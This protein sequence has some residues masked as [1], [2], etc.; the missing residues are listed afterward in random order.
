METTT[1]WTSIATIFIAASL[2]A[3]CSQPDENIADIPACP[4]A[5]MLALDDS[6]SFEVPDMGTVDMGPTGAVIHSQSPPAGTVFTG[7]REFT[8]VYTLAPPQEPSITCEVRSLLIDTSPPEIALSGAD[9]E[10]IW[11]EPFAPVIE[12]SD[13][14]DPQPEVRITVN[15]LDFEPGQLFE[16]PGLYTVL[17]NANDHRGNSSEVKRVVEIAEYPTVDALVLPAESHCVE[18]EGYIELD[19]TILVASEADL[20]DLNLDTVQLVAWD[21]DGRVLGVL[22]PTGLYDPEGRYNPETGQVFVRDGY[23]SANFTSNAIDRTLSAC[24]AVVQII[25]SGLRNGP[26]T[27]DLAGLAELTPILSPVAVIEQ[28]GMLEPLQDA[29]LAATPTA[30]CK[31]E[32][33]KNLAP[34]ETPTGGVARSKP[35][36]PSDHDAA[37]YASWLTNEAVKF[38]H[39]ATL[40]PGPFDQYAAPPWERT[41]IRSLPGEFE[42][43][44]KSKV[45]RYGLKSYKSQ[46]TVEGEERDQGLYIAQTL[47]L[48]RDAKADPGRDAAEILAQSGRLQRHGQGLGQ[49][50]YQGDLHARRHSRRQ[51]RHHGPKT[52]SKPRARG[53]EYPGPCG[54]RTR[55]ST[56]ASRTGTKSR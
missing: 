28:A 10:R 47:R 8:L 14:I 18:R 49:D 55:T 22:S 40:F 15:G 48:R 37:L 53:R 26:G 50:S 5:L 6:G 46:G 52:K 27:F 11:G 51:Q 44:M 31:L 1:K 24:P 33:T 4:E 21:G 29:M 7:E 35:T 20:R 19:T 45:A 30:G 34:K 16:A 12:V 3:G 23:L 25:A 36:A 43:K 54:H 13:A 39:G 17:V 42:V 38:H 9:Q 2:A 41:L 56:T 32:F